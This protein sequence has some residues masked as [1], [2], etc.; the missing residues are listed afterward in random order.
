MIRRVVSLTGTA[1]PSPQPATAVLMPTTRLAESASAP[2]EL[3]GLSAAS[4]WMTS[5]TTRAVRPSRVGSDRPTPLTTPAVTEPARPSGLPTATTS[6]PTASVPASPRTAGG[7]V[8]VRARTTA[9]SLSGSAPTTSTSASVPSANTAR[10]ARARDTPCAFVSSS[11]S[12]VNPSAQT[13]PTPPAGTAPAGVLGL[14]LPGAE[15]LLAVPAG[16]P[17]PRPLLV[18][19]HGAGGTAEQGLAAVGGPAGDRGVLVLATTSAASTW[20][21]I[22]GGL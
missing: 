22:A 1:S 14:H 7:G 20:D 16:E 17:G 3:P 13:A 4:V 10:P 8:A 18:F 2:P 19:F 21:L 11:P 15:A 12:A 9:R 5:S 6:C